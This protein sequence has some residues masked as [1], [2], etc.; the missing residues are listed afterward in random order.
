[1]AGNGSA[2]VLLDGDATSVRQAL[3]E[4]TA[5]GVEHLVYQSSATVYGA[6]PDNAVPLSEAT[7]L[8]PNPGASFAVGHA[9][10]ERLVA[11]WKAARPGTT[12]TV[13]RPATTV[14]PGERTR[15]AP[16]LAGYAGVAVRG[17]SRPVQ[18]VHV[19][20]VAAAVALA[21]ERRLDGT[22]NVAPDG[23]IADSTARAVAGGPLRLSLPE[24]V[25]ERLTRL[26][27][28]VLAYAKHPWVVAN[29]RLRAEG[30]APEHTNEEALVATQAASWRDLSPRRR[31]E[32]AL[33]VTGAT[34]LGTVAGAVALIRRSHR[35]RNS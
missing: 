17:A 12:A 9:E 10:G 33:G 11:D 21:V 27:P 25:V 18:A 28:A 31:Q 20:D 35:R 30:W 14:T 4:A 13:L 16:L 8:R 23:W 6:W 34:L 24:S 5:S 3:A 19:D 26:S 2:A 29:D 1:M 22:Y 7:A 32:L 15:L